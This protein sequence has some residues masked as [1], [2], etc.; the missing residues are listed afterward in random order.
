MAAAADVVSAWPGE[1][2]AGASAHTAAF[3]L[4][5][6][7]CCAS[8]PTH[9]INPPPP[10]PSPP[11]PKSRSIAALAAFIRAS[12]ADYTTPGAVSEAERDR[13]EAE[14][15][16]YVRACAGQVAALERAVATAGG[17]ASASPASTTTA[18]TVSAHR[19]GVALIL[20]ERLGAVSG[21]FDR[22]RAGRYA[23]S[24]AAR[25]AW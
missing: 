18:P 13:I 11:P 6:I 22:A 4:F 19:H 20:A 23:A 8:P 2:G 5:S 15:G 16:G 3:S 14:A 17:G 10:S 24:A 9:P 7:P 25:A 12:R 1:V 21:V